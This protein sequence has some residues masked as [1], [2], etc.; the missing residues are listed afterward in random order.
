MKPM[1]GNYIFNT[2]NHILL[3]LFS[4]MCIYPFIYVGALSLNEASDAARGGIYF[5]PRVFTLQ[6]YAAIFNNTTII[7]AYGVTVAR[8]LLTLLLHLFFTIMFAFALTKK[9]FRPRKFLNWW[10]VIPMY[11][12]GGLIPFYIILRYLGLLNNFLVYIIPAIFSSF[13]ILLV[14]TALKD[15]PPALEEAAAIDGA[16]EPRILFGILTPMIKPVLAAIA[17]FTGVAAWNDWYTGFTYISNT[18]LWC[19]QNVL[20]YL[21]RSNE[22]SN[23]VM[24]AKMKSGLKMTVTAESI[25]MAMLI[26][27][28]L[29]ILCI[30][31]FLQKY[32]IKGIMVGSLKE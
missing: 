11:F 26:V 16:S 13:N 4:I 31:P 17:L 27:T 15:I 24:I 8:V 18:K 9:E 7:T 2:I 23:L 29:P 10:I 30:Y 6:N 14:R 28:T 5:W 21:L 12:T 32:F 25:K 22:A 1:I 19:V 3:I 20:L